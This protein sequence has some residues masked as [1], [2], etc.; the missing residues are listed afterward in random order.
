MEDGGRFRL[1]FQPS[2]RRVSFGD[3]DDGA[4]R[5]RAESGEAS[6]RVEA[7]EIQRVD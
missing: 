5:R 1:L 7:L 6:A 2:E 3:D 4:G